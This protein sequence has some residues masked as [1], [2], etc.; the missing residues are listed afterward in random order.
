MFAR[1]RPFPLW[2][3]RLVKQIGGVE[4]SNQVIEVLVTFVNLTQHDLNLH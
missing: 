3:A 2:L 4:T 1:S